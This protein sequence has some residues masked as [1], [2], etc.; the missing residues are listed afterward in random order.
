MRP[1]DSP[2]ASPSP[3]LTTPDRPATDHD[4][5]VPDHF[6]ETPTAGLDP[7]PDLDVP[8]SDYHHWPGHAPQSHAHP[9]QPSDDAY[10]ATE[11]GDEDGEEDH[12]GDGAG[13]LG[14]EDFNVDMDD[15]VENQ[16]D[17]PPLLAQDA[18]EPP[19]AAPAN[20][21]AMQPLQVLQQL[22]DLQ[23][24][25]DAEDAGLNAAHIMALTNPNPVS[26][27]P[28]NP[29]VLQFLQLWIWQSQTDTH[30]RTAGR[31]P[32]S[33]GLERM[34][35]ECPRRV[36]YNQLKGDN[37]DFQGINWTALGIT[38]NAARNR[39]MATFHN[40]V[41]RQ[42]SD[43]WNE[44]QPDRLLRPVENYFRYQS[45]DIR[46]D[47]RLLHFQLR[48]ILGCASRSRTFYP[49]ENT[50]KEHD[51]T[52]GRTKTAMH[53]DNPSDAHISTL[54]AGEDV[55]IA[56]GFYGGYRY[57]ALDSEDIE[58]ADGR[59]TDNISGITNHVQIHSSRFSSV[60]LAAFASND[61]GF[62]VLDLSTNRIISETMYDFA[63]NCSALSPDKRLRV[64][65]GDHQNVLIADAERG[66][67]LQR[68][69]GHRDYGFACDW[70]P[71]GW[72]VATGNQDKSI[73]I[74]D[75]RKWKNSSGQSTSIAVIR[76]E[77][78]GARCL[79]FSPLGSGKRILVAMEEADYIDTIDAQTFNTR[80]TSDIF[81]ELGGISFANGGQ[82]L[83][84]LSCDAFR[85]GIIRLERCDAGAEDNFSYAPR[86]Y[87]EPRGWWR[88]PGY[89]W[90]QSPE[91]VVEE[92]DSQETLT[93]KRRKAAM[94]EDWIF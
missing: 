2:P 37:Y 48:N 34:A 8:M 21:M 19:V 39:R 92:P 72:T 1:L 50:I 73:R 42:E 52:T 77:I 51:P 22:Q 58:Y 81:G 31:V 25:Q 63:L 3:T 30:L 54:T 70:A 86:K 11:D 93:Q 13:F 41:N 78:A 44:S 35:R 6:A 23:D 60:P 12:G 66:D 28:E 80:Q 16:H 90:L 47:V 83:I 24:L 87:Q 55:L 18:I 94:L 71:D 4:A 36:E 75:A 88:T 67:I 69:E 43:L 65:V 15:F 7:D 56:G 46:R 17:T 62:R 57:R 26:L 20:A 33:R 32:C 45:M 38:R 9:D 49:S 91:Q 10:D 76:S 74:W 61:Y 53:F 59:L 27:G 14:L 82:D 5:L 68:L 29:S 85:G 79:R 64:V 40:Y 84:A 89:D